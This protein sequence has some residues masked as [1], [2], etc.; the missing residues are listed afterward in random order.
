VLERRGRWEADRSTQVVHELPSIQR[1]E[2]VDV[3]RCTVDDG[4]GQRPTV[5]HERARRRLVWIQ[6]IPELKLR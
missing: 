4:Q 2:Q 6:P 5:R 3:A 1:I